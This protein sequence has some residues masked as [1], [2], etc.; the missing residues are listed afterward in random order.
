METASK[1]VIDAAHDHI[2]DTELIHAFPL[3]C[4]CNIRD[5]RMLISA[6]HCSADDGT[7]FNGLNVLIGLE[8][9]FRA[10]W[11]TDERL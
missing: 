5:A 11:R 4:T 7:P 2:Q 1:M 9:N 3:C 10:Q 6:V 8:K